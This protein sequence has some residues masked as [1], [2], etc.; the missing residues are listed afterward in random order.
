MAH[1]KKRG[2]V[3]FHPPA[4]KMVADLP[5]DEEM[6]SHL[7]EMKLHDGFQGSCIQISPDHSEGESKDE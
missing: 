2:H 5:G 1:S 7:E 4:V 3:E 6:R